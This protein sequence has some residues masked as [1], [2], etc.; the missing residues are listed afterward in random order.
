MLSSSPDSGKDLTS[1]TSSLP[2]LE[3][4]SPDLVLKEIFESPQ[5][6]LRDEINVPLEKQVRI[7][8]KNPILFN[9]EKQLHF[10]SGIFPICDP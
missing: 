2:P 7:T 9:L 10:L 5:N 3:S 1:A 6:E 8:E 4:L